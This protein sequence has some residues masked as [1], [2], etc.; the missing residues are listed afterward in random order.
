LLEDRRINPVLRRDF[1]NTDKEINI[2]YEFRNI[3]FNIIMKMTK[4]NNI[5]M[6]ISLGEYFKIR[7]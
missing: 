7:Y 1:Y 2:K 5:N 6:G 4:S 3:I